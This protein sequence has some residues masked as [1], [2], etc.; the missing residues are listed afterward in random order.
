MGSG[1]N[2]NKEEV[3]RDIVGESKYIEQIGVEN[4]DTNSDKADTYRDMVKSEMIP[5]PWHV[6]KIKKIG[7]YD[8]YVKNAIN[9]S[10]ELLAE[11]D[12]TKQLV[13]LNSDYKRMDTLLERL[14]N[15][16]DEEKKTKSQLFD[17]IVDHTKHLKNPCNP[18]DLVVYT[19]FIPDIRML[20][21]SAETLSW[22]Y[23]VHVQGRLPAKL[24]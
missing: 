20:D 19:N 22:L 17:M 4:I 5:D 9:E 6:Q 23:T 13:S 21:T 15:Y 14:L 12:N 7:L 10:L 3:I 18:S 24:G 2:E 11:R 16:S 1:N 8:M